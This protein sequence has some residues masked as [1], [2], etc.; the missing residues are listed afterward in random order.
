MNQPGRPDELESVEIIASGYEWI[1][2][3]CEQ[4]HQ[5]METAEEVQCQRCHRRYTVTDIHHATP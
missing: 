3:S 2:P 1:C 5:T 4:F